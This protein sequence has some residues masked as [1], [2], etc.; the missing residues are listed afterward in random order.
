M[1][2]HATYFEPKV[3]TWFVDETPIKIKHKG[4]TESTGDPTIPQLNRSVMLYR[5]ALRRQL[6]AGVQVETIKKSKRWYHG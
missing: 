6:E 5:A 4:C 1:A 3:Y 2:K